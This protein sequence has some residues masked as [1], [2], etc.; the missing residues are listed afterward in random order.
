[1][2]I[3]CVAYQNGQ[4]IAS[5]SLDEVQ[6]YMKQPDCF[7]WASF[8]DSTDVDF[9]QMMQVFDLHPLALDEFEGVTNAPSLLS[10]VRRFFR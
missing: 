5:V 1:M 10:T 2:L 6:S 9:E 7:I 3:D 8:Q 4:K